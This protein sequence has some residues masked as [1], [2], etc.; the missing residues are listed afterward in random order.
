MV[1]QGQAPSMVGPARAPQVM[2]PL[3]D[4]E[5]LMEDLHQSMVIAPTTLAPEAEASS[6]EMVSRLFLAHPRSDQMPRAELDSL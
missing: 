6:A 4:S 5:S 2:V 1:I 3:K